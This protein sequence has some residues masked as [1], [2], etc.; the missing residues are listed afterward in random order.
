MEPSN[1]GP[2][3]VIEQ[4]HLAWDAFLKG[5]PEPGKALY[6]RRDDVS[7]GNPYGPFAVGWKQ[8]EQTMERAAALYRD[9]EAVAFEPV[10]LY[11]SEDLACLVEVERY[12]GKVGGADEPSSISLR[13]TSVLRREDGTWKIVHRHADPITAPRAPESVLQS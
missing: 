7:L 10:A 11:A 9:G 3:G 2:E 5:N 8:V 4:S 1:D 6:S 12:R 13:V